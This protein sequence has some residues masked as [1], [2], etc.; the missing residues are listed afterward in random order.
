MIGSAWKTK[1]KQKNKKKT[2]D[3][4]KKHNCK[5]EWQLRNN[6]MF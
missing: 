5:P 2:N 3:K 1:K 6:T 4:Q